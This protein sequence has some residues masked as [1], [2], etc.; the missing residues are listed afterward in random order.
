MSSAVSSRAPSPSPSLMSIIY[1]GFKPPTGRDSLPC[2]PQLGGQRTIHSSPSSNLFQPIRTSNSSNSIG[3]TEANT[4]QSTLVTVRAKK[5]PTPSPDV[6]ELE[7]DLNQ[8]EEQVE[9]END[10][11]V[12]PPSSHSSPLHTTPPPQESSSHQRSRSNEIDYGLSSRSRGISAFRTPSD[13][14][15]FRPLSVDSVPLPPAGSIPPTAS[16]GPRVRL[17]SAGSTWLKDES[18]STFFGPS[19]T[20]EQF[21]HSDEPLLNVHTVTDC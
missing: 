15:T 19:G 4:P 10:D 18:I 5:S 13:S 21:L 20:I 2:T 7:L 8:T 11:I 14:I 3:A 9:G 12:T 17:G 6:V 16:G 1:P